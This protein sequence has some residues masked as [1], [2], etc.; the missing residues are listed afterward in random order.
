M[1]SSD[2][3]GMAD[4]SVD[5]GDSSAFGTSP[6][7][8]KLWLDYFFDWCGASLERRFRR[9]LVAFAFSL[10]VWGLGLL[11]ALPFGLGHL[12]V[13]TPGVY[14]ILV[15]MTWCVNALRW[16][17]QIYHVVTNRVRP[18]FPISDAEYQKLVRPFA[19]K[20]TRN[21][22]FVPRALVASLVVWSYLAAVVYSPARIRSVLMLG[23]PSSFPVAWR[24]GTDLIPKLII[25]DLLAGVCTLCVYTGARITLATLPLY[26]R[27]AELPVIPLPGIVVELFRG[28]LNV[29]LTGAAMWSFGIVLAEVGWGARLDALGITFVVFVTA[30]GIL[31]YLVPRTFVKRIWV[32]ARDE[33]IHIALEHY[34]RSLTDSPRVDQISQLTH[35]IQT[36]QA[37]ADVGLS[38]NQ[39]ASLAGGQLMPLIPLLINAAFPSLRLPF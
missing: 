36:I 21:R 18:C 29:Y 12:Y 1:E 23:F 20:A 34:Y 35:Y 9:Y 19:E 16:L 17:S 26:V 28:V 10:A 15:G 13:T 38:F 24:T 31:A 25:L 27:L 6:A 2:L 5:A 37:S 3:G 33:A 30:L 39:L 32:K 7:E 8:Y 22:E 14:V 4:F 11:I